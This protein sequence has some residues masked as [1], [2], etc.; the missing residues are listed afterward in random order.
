M[1][2][3]TGR[4]AGYCAGYAT[5]G[6]TNPVPGGGFG[7]GRGRGGIGRGLGLGFRGGRG[8]GGRRAAYAPPAYPPAAVP[9][10]APAAYAAQ[11]TAQQELDALK[12]QA[13]YLAESL[14]GVR[15][16]I[17]ELENNTEDSQ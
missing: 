6:F 5:P 10:A 7:L 12:N 13:E 9:Y 11:P 3:M 2:P 4:A 1:G 8:G 16:R 14:S 17:E 15:K